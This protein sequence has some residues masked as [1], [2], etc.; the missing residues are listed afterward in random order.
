M[1]LW[2]NDLTVL[3]KSIIIFLV[4]II[5][6]IIIIIVIKWRRNELKGWLWIHKFGRVSKKRV[7][8][9]FENTFV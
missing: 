4:F 2:R 6:I 9:G 3:C 7:A 5:I 8:N 1:R